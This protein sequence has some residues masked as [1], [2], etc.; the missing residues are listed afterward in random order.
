MSL[1]F[2]SVE[3]VL[4]IHE[5]TIRVEGGRPGLRG[6]ALLESALMMPLQRFEGQYLH[7]DL[8][9]MAA[10]YHF[11]LAQNHAFHD[12]NKRAAAFSMVIFL[13]ANGYATP[14]ARE[15]EAVTMRVASSDMSKAEVAI[16]LRG[17]V[18]EY[19]T[20]P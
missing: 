1:L 15:L 3:D 9:S 2:L 7:E 20:N 17:V 16:W 6:A 11:H 14:D 8:A 18:G 19:P 5:D 12:A 4:A 13:H 10:A